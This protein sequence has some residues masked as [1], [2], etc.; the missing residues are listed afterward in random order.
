MKE[1]CF[2]FDTKWDEAQIILS[3]TY[4]KI[5]LLIKYIKYEI[6]NIK[7]KMIKNGIL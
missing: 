4:F 2:N 1:K 7:V 5:F 3:K 6:F